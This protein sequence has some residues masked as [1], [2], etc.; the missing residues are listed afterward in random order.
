MRK[1]TVFVTL[2]ISGLLLAIPASGEE[3]TPEKKKRAGLV[4]EIR[5]GVLAHDVD[6]LWSGTQ[7]EDG[8][9]LNGELIFSRPSFSLLTG[10]VRPNLGLTLNLNGDTSKLYGGLLWEL[11]ATSALF[12]DLGAG[13]AL[14]NGELDTSDPDKKSLGS[15]LLFRIAI[16][17]GYALSKHH[18]VS[19]MFDHISN[20]YLANPNEGLDTLGIRYGYRF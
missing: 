12:F 13:L 4:H 14:H 20:A 15:R 6:G 7:K 18:R 8:I 16:E 10:T 17:L 9:D 19:I 11:W 2:L 3:Q 1:I 5:T